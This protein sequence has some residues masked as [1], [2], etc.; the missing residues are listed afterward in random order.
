LA[1]LS[2]TYGGLVK[3]GGGITVNPFHSSVLPWPAAP[4]G[5]KTLA[6]EEDDAEAMIAVCAED[7]TS[8]GLR[9]A[10]I[11]RLLYDTGLRRASVAGLLRVGIRKEGSRTLLRV[12]VKGGQEAD[13]A[14]PDVT[15]T[16]LQA[17]LKVAPKS[18]YVFPARKDKSLHANIINQIVADRAREAGCDHVAPHSFRARFITSSYDAGLPEYEIQAAV[19]HADPK[20]T[21]AYDRRARGLGVADAV[22]TARKGKEK[23]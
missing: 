9:D 22:A 14:L 3:L 6:V 10:A 16:A 19:H 4:V 18:V 13:V 12:V 7:S 5:G 1:A 11:L 15:V 20:I 2:S 8:A 23:K 17:W 21:R